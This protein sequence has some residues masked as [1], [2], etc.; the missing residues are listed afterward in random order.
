MIEIRRSGDR[1]RSRAHWLD[2]RHSFSFADYYD[3]AWMEFGALRVLNEDWIRPGM[4]FGPH[5]HRDMEILTWVLDGVLEHRD[6]QGHVSRIHPG[7]V[8]RMRAGKGIVHS[9]TNPSTDETLHLLQIWL[10]PE[11]PGLEPD[12]EER[13]LELSDGGLTAIATHGGQ[14]GG[15]A[16]DQ[17]A[18]VLAARLSGGDEVCQA[19]GPDRLAWVQITRGAGTVG[20]EPVEAGDAA[21]LTH[22][23]ELRLRGD[24]EL[25]ALVFDLARAGTQR[26]EET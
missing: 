18:S 19:L 11:R 21:A 10:R 9:E 1:G 25:E 2:S 15:V 16:L 12:Y 6:S 23:S 13:E 3:P 7:R 5:P 24:G 17:D 26:R 22:E 14:G 20:D 8:Q 4:G